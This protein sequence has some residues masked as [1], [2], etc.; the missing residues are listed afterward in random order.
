MAQYD[1]STLNSS[2]LEELVCDL[3]NAQQGEN[4]IVRYRTFKDGKD[5]GIDFLYSTTTNQY[6]HVGQVK[7]FRETGFAGLSSV[8]KKQELKK[9]KKIN[10]SKY[11]FATSVDLTVS[12]VQEISDI[13]NPF[14]KNLHD[15]YGS[16]DLNRLLELHEDIL[17]NHY[18]LWF[19]DTSI[20]KKI[21][22]SDLMFRSSQ[23]SNAEFKRRL[24]IYV[25]TP[26]FENARKS[27][28]TNNFIII[29]GQPGVGKTTLAEMLVYEYIKNDYKLTYIIDDIKDA[30]RTICQDKSKQIIYFDDFLGS[31]EV[32]INRAKGS[33][34]SLRKII[35][36]ITSLENKVL[37][38]TTRSGLLNS[39][40]AESE[41]LNRFNI[42]AKESVLELNEYS[43][44]IKK[45]ILKNHIEDSELKDELKEFLS[46][47]KT[48][49][50]IINHTSFSP[51]VVEFITN[52]EVV[53][54][55]NVRE[56]E[57]FLYSSINSAVDIWEHAYNYQIK[58]DDRLLLNTLLSFGDSADITELEN[59]FQSRIE[60]EVLTNNKKKEILA[61][62]KSLKR[63]IDG[64]VILKDNNKKIQFINPS[65]TDF[66]VAYLRRDNDEIMR[67][68]K[69]V[70]YTSQLTK[71]LF[72]LS[73]SKTPEIPDV[74]KDRLLDDYSSF[75]SKKD[76]D[77]ELIQLALVINKYI[78]SRKSENVV[79]EILLKINDWSSLHNDYSL[80]IYFREFLKTVRENN[81]ISQI[82]NERIV[83][84]LSELINGESN[85]NDATQMLEDFI[86][87]YSLN[88][89]FE[90][91]HLIEE[92]FEDLLSE[93]IYE[94]IE[95]LK[96]IITSE[97]EASEKKTEILKIIS[98]L[99]GSGLTISTNLEEFDDED[100]LTLAID[101]EF[102]RQMEKDD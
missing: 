67:I 72:S 33:E 23:F 79:C 61:F 74:L 14:I 24:R 37:V 44:D 81:R 54:R 101:N 71:R 97:E 80:N 11:I 4:G 50:F 75:I 64:F 2:D 32:E 84:I 10:P 38:F 29:T 21:L 52:K 47:S 17:K 69:S 28:K 46:S 34:T 9:V 31:N 85:I 8:L 39:A 30:E 93:Y 48:E 25:Q 26:I 62:R 57:D 13:F 12:N 89:R 22:D 83:D 100:W 42:K 35:R 40:I 51:R 88:L 86:W 5:K 41:N 66:L 60:L 45:A 58:E 87:Q 3:L 19:S 49:S 6:E 36:M 59:A 56:Y 15:I 96:E 16:K 94:E 78:K 98:R 90:D 77:G 27:L 82:V 7:H 53:N 55:M 20:L 76:Q 68:A 63:L 18:K 1:F 65:L 73:F 95:E 70:R 43:K 99:N 91:T 102:R 92:H